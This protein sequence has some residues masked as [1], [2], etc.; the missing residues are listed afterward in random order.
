MSFRRKTETP[1]CANSRAI[2]Q[3][4]EN[5]IDYPQPFSPSVRGHDPL[6][7]GSDHD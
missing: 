4:G 5:W 3:E 7:R 6:S 2:L 1:D